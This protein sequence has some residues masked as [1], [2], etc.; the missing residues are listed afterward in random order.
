MVNLKGEVPKYIL[1]EALMKFRGDIKVM[2]MFLINGP[3]SD[4][5]KPHF[6]MTYSDFMDEVDELYRELIDKY[7]GE[8]G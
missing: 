3:D 8:G 4:K 7:L 1:L 5:R 2:A 6:T